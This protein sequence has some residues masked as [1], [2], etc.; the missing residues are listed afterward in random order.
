MEDTH[1]YMKNWWPC[2]HVIGFEHTFVNAFN[3]VLEAIA[4]KRALT[5][6]F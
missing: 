6:Q 4:G 3:D 5:P 1:P 2:G